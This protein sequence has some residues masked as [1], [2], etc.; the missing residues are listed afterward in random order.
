MKKTVHITAVN[1]WIAAIKAFRTVFGVSLRYAT[2]VIPNPR[3]GG[4][5]PVLVPAE[6]VGEQYAGHYV[7]KKFV[8]LAG[9]S[10]S[11]SE[12]IDMEGDIDYDALRQERNR[13]WAETQAWYEQQSDD[14]KRL[15]D[16]RIRL[17]GPY[18]V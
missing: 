13:Q 4:S 12:E 7:W 18:A 1:N 8:D 17:S 9:D 2:S 5:F 15:V 3:A 14:V 6:F 16:L 11:F 10:I